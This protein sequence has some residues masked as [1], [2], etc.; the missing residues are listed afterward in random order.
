MRVQEKVRD[1]KRRS[2]T[3]S[4]RYMHHFHFFMRLTV[5]SSAGIAYAHSDGYIYST[6][7]CLVWSNGLLRDSGDAVHDIAIALDDA[8]PEW[9]EASK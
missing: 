9:W 6:N 1:N 5:R 8:M 7:L 3:I 4:L 2:G